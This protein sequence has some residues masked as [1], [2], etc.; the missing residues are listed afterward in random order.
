MANR[1]TRSRR[2][3]PRWEVDGLVSSLGAVMDLSDSGVQVLTDEP[4]NPDVDE[5]TLQCV[6]GEFTVPVRL[7]WT[8]QVGYHR[9]FSGLAFNNATRTQI[10][11]VA[12]LVLSHYRQYPKCA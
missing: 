6:E 7:I 10:N 4:I 2:R 8:R 1:A 5:I 9:Y 3:N 11:K 12:D